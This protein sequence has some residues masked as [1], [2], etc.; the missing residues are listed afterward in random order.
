LDLQPGDAVRVKNRA[1]IAET[2]D[3]R[4]RNRG[5]GIC[6]EMLR[7][8]GGEAEVRARVERIIDEKTGKMRELRNTVILQNLH[9]KGMEPAPECLCYHELGDCPRGEL[10]FWREIWL[11]RD[12]DGGF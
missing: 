9:K 12:T 2:L 3:H 6:L 1:Q 10:M 4:G 7:Y 11:E 8:C 5:M